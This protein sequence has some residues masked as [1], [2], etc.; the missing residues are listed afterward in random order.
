MYYVYVQPPPISKYNVNLRH[1]KLKKT[2]KDE[3]R[4][5]N[6][7]INSSTIELNYV[8]WCKQ[9]GW[10]SCDYGNQWLEKLENIVQ[11]RSQLSRCIQCFVLFR[12][13]VLKLSYSISFNEFILYCQTVLS[14][15]TLF[16]CHWYYSIYTTLLFLLIT[17]SHCTDIVWQLKQMHL[18]TEFDI[19]NNWL[20]DRKIFCFSVNNLYSR[21]ILV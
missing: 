7:F 18:H 21:N 17:S 11:N 16:Y 10:D 4:K 20:T 2:R 3:T 15:H 14:V 13:W 6:Q 5:L 8:V 1:S 9:S 19:V 12:F